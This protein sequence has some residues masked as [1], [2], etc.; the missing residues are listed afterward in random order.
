M[1]ANELLDSVVK[2]HGEL[3]VSDGVEP[4]LLE[5]VRELDDEIH[6]MIK[7]NELRAEESFS[8]RLVELEAQFASEH[9]RLERLTREV[10]DRLAQM[11]I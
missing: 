8:Q 3:E 11:G 5:Q 9:P 1:R 7:S 2:L 6:Q 10:I 4:E